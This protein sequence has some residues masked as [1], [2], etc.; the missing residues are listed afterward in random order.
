MTE[1]EKK[2]GVLRFDKLR[3][4]GFKS[5]VEPTTLVIRS[6]LT[7]I[8]GPNGC[9]KSNLVEAL[10][11]VMGET[12]P[13]QMRSS[14]MD[15]VIF[16]GTASRPPRNI[17]EII[18]SLDNSDRVAPSRFN[19]SDEI[20]ISRRIEREKGSLYRVNGK[21]TRARDVQLLFADASTGARS[22]A[23]VSQGR[24]SALIAAR[25]V[26]R[27]TI[28]EEAAG[29]TGLH[30]RRHE[31]ELRLRGAETN[32]ERLDDILVTLDVQLQ[33][34]KKQSRQAARY[35]NLSGH[36]RRAEATF[37]Y[38][39][40]LKAEAEFNGFRENLE[41][42]E[43][44]VMELTRSAGRAATAQAEAAAGLPELRRVEVEK[45]AQLQRLVVARE[46]LDSEEQ[47]I[48]ST[49]EQCRLRLDQTGSDS[50]RERS[51]L[52]DAKSAIEVLDKELAE[53]K[54]A[55]Q[56]EASAA[57]ESLA[58]LSA[59][60][61]AVNKQETLLAEITGRAADDEARRESLSRTLEDLRNRQRRLIDRSREI[62]GQLADLKSRAVDSEAMEKAELALA[63]VRSELEDTR[64]KAQ[65]AEN[66][67][68]EHSE[69]VS[70][71]VSD[72]H[73][74]QTILSGLEAEERA[75]AELLEA[76]ELEQWPALI[77]S[78]SVEPGY[79]AALGAALGDDLSAAID[80]GAPVC[81]RALAPLPQAP[82][83]P[84]GV[85]PLSRYVTGP[86][87][88]SRRLRQV[89]VVASQEQGY[90]CCENLAQGQR[91]VS[92]GGGLWRWDGY[93]V[94]DGAATSATARLEQKNRLKEVRERIL[95]ARTAAGA[96]AANAEKARQA[97]ANAVENEKNLRQSLQAADTSYARIRE[98][99]SEIR[100]K[101]AAHAS[102]LAALTSAA[103]DVEAD[104]EETKSQIAKIE[105]SLGSLPDSRLVG[106][107]IAKHRTMLAKHRAVQLE[108]QTADDLLKR[109]SQ[110]RSRRNDDIARELNSW[111]RRAIEAGNQLRQLEQRRQS[112]NL[113]Y[114]R[115]SAAPEEIA[116]KRRTLLDKIEASEKNRNE[117][118]DRL[119]ESENRLADAERCLR[120]AESNLALA[121]EQRVRAEGEQLQGQQAIDE[122]LERISEKLGC[123]PD[124]LFE[125]SGLK[126]DGD[127]PE[128]EAV[129]RKMDRLQRE[130]ETMGPVNLRA[131]QETNEI[132]EQVETLVNE[133]DDL[134]KAI[135][136]LR[137]GIGELNRE[138]RQ[139]LLASFG[140]VDRH[141][142]ELFA[143]LFGG[144][145]AHLKLTDSDDPLEA[146]L[147]IMASPPGKRLQS[148]S[149]LSGGE[150]AL[151][152]LALLFG[153]FLTNPAP[154]CVLDE[155]DAPLDDANVDRFCSMLSEIAEAGGT[156]FMV[157]TH[158]RMTMARM[159]RLYGVTMSERGISQLVSV[160][161]QC[162][163]ALKDVG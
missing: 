153:V 65:A 144:G 74:K 4:S 63:A 30:S 92:T 54:T 15:D 49:T 158:H 107:E 108:C 27:R 67:R 88:L 2:S 138:G 57:A 89:G 96:S 129:E 119:A 51:L 70:L 147:E 142:Q 125:A 58:R 131:E 32:L 91:L 7:G 78:V 141:F 104:I 95:S 75:L 23:M 159:D 139:R 28:L 19:D 148:L 34:L 85:E 157:I 61:E 29:I 22:T 110:T 101:A 105:Q 134:T 93:T 60:N 84:D 11:W 16:N 64:T 112:L 81:W 128:L 25:P 33:S 66:A 149:L 140:E 76:G 6:G 111:N 151:T 122:L 35:R 163:E 123:T 26:D 126:D 46:S 102:R 8:V 42:A 127:L 94:A 133:R 38:L 62:D 40:W 109:G 113:E 53:I 155:V 52:N 150:Q 83:L 68:A 82:D 59:A 103:G 145:R 69:A 160:D 106:D 77:D 116:A 143:R 86:K 3:L 50:E 41:K 97:A 48:K 45:A 124:Q 114:D 14:E 156:R 115:L 17:A 18:L 161:L 154:I 39:R 146:G 79:E 136:K 13:K 130:R 56:N 47:G 152:A 132:T 1:A 118:A 43:A 10:R 162:A 80:D 121:R 12:S 21:E 100:E 24:I 71:A 5:F 73:Q 55:A 135:E 99:H 36:V 117:A 44:E 31:A 120:T 20:D 72:L 90:G 87:A 137:R 9:G 98:S 37:F